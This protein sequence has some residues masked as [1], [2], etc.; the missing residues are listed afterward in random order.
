[1]IS[2]RKNEYK[3]TKNYRKRFGVIRGD[4][5]KLFFL[6]YYCI[7]YSSTCIINIINCYYK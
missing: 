2:R 1:M 4:D 7:K 5:E 3:K 6:R